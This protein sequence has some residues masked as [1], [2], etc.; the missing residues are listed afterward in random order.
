MTAFKRFEDIKGWQKSRLLCSKI[1]QVITTTD[2]SKDY[3]LRDQ[4]NSS[5]GS[6]MDNIAEGFGRAGNR[7]FVQFLEISHGSCRECQ[8][9]LY[10]ILDRN[11]I[12]RELFNELYGLCDEIGKML[13]GLINYIQKTP[14]KGVK[15]K[16]HDSNAPQLNPDPKTKN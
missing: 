8:S 9:Q 14:L 1:Y 2:L 3:K 5:S 15:F 13:I 11:Y 4:I 12:N 10:R 6:T 16:T 7:E